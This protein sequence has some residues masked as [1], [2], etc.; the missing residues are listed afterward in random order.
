[1]KQLPWWL[2]N[3]QYGYYIP[4]YFQAGKESTA[5]DSGVRFLALAI[6]QIFAVFLSGT[7]VTVFGYYVGSP[8]NS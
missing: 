7:L 1:M 2:N 4:I 5:T 8:S 6:P 3:P